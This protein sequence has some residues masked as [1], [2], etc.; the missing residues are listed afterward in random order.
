MA[1]FRSQ[2]ASRHRSIGVRRNQL[3]RDADH[4]EAGI[5]LAVVTSGM[6]LYFVNLLTAWLTSEISSGFEIDTRDGGARTAQFL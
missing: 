2:V 1:S 5:P 6:A 3:P 4:Q